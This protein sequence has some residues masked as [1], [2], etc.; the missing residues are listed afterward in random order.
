MKANWIVFS[1]S[2]LVLLAGAGIGF[3]SWRE[4]ATKEA[5]M[6]QL[7][8]DVDSALAAKP[9]DSSELSRLWSRLEK[10]AA[11]GDDPRVPLSQAR[12]ELARGHFESAA[13]LLEPLV[14]IGSS[15]LLALRAGVLAWQMWYARGGKDAN[16]RDQLGR[17]ALLLAESAS[18]L[19]GTVEDAFAAWQCAVRLPEDPATQRFR[20]LL[21]QQFADTLQARTV[22]ALSNAQ[23][24]QSL[25]PMQVLAEEWSTA[26]TAVESSAPA[27]AVVPMELELA[28]A[29]LDL[30]HQEIDRAKQRLAGL[31]QQNP[32][33][34]EVRNW[35]ATVF[36]ILALNNQGAERDRYLRQRDQQLGWLDSNAQKEDSRRNKW[37]EMRGTR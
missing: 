18:Q 1:L 24:D 21:M 20:E 16:E 19:G 30:Q 25:R 9:T 2:G 8:A 28:M 4:Q 22:L 3:K 29:I 35:S 10:T 7:V 11:L 6:E 5:S 13:N 27:P 34:V 32:S 23:L 14:G 12:I 36:H 37:R 33:L 15:N 31:L 17:R 26:I